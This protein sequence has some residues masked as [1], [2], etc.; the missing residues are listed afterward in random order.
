MFVALGLLAAHF[1]DTFNLRVCLF[2]PSV[3]LA[4]HRMARPYWPVILSKQICVQ[5]LVCKGVSYSCA[6][7]GAMLGCQRQ[8][9]LLHTQQQLL[10][11]CLLCAH[12]G[13]VLLPVQ[14]GDCHEWSRHMGHLKRCAPSAPWN[15]TPEQQQ[16]ALA[17]AENDA[18]AA[19]CARTTAHRDCQP[20]AL[21]PR[22]QHESLFRFDC[23]SHVQVSARPQRQC[24]VS[25][26]TTAFLRY[27]RT[28]MMVIFRCPDALCSD[29][30]SPSDVLQQQNNVQ[31]VY[32]T[33]PFPWL[34]SF[35]RR[36][37]HGNSWL[38]GSG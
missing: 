33:A 17:D 34:G 36:P 14:G 9:A 31:Q 10:P 1:V 8:D 29:A 7:L 35:E 28:N 30:N 11:C 21:C 26:I 5:T 12:G 37:V 15:G 2:Q 13:K 23:S 38:H 32:H 20:Q 4:L 19:C 22:P 16:E 6:M 27:I 25:E 24:S 3:G 18:G